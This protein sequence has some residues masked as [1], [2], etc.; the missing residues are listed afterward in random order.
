MAFRTVVIKNRC[1]LSYSLN[2]LIYRGEV[3]KKINIS[4]ISTLIIESTAVSITSSLIAELSKHKINVIF[5]N[6]KHNPETQLIPFYGCH[7]SPTKIKDQISWS[8]ETKDLIWQEI[9][10]NKIYSQILNLELYDH[11]QSLMLKEYKSNVRLG[12]KTNREGHAAKV[13]FNA[14]FGNDFARSKDILENMYL[15]YGYTIVLSHVNRFVVSSGYL[16]QI[17]VHHKNEYNSYNFSCDLMEPF[18]PI[19]DA[20]AISG[21]LTEDNFKKK[22]SNLETIKVKIKNQKTNLENA[23]KI[24]C[25][26]VFKALN[27]KDSSCIEMYD[28]YEF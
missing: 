21:L 19:I 23:I 27:T 2:Y 11:E 8:N 24:Y 3:E 14:M 10:K 6:N 26:S 28:A 15:N 18:R 16:T 20:Y 9:V 17:G 1:K 22:L 12:D 7:N 4:E 5:C 13:Y 25:S